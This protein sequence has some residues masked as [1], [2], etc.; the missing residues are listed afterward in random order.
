MQRHLNTPGGAIYG[1]ALSRPEEYPKGPPQTFE[2]PIE[3]LWLS[4]AYSGGGG[5]TGAISAGAGAV[6]A[7]LQK[8]HS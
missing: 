7:A 1:F 8:R 3:G 5:F 4:S 6:R 2:T